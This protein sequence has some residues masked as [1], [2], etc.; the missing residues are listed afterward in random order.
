MV[1]N[2]SMH[3]EA[4]CMLRSF[5]FSEDGFPI[6]KKYRQTSDSCKTRLIDR[7]MRDR[8]ACNLLT[9]LLISIVAFEKSGVA[10]EH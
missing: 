4:A 8:R 1:T 7:A 6:I 2:I 5:V 3:A 9:T 10:L